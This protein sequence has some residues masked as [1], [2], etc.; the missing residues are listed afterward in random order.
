MTAGIANAVGVRRT[1]TSLIVWSGQGTHSPDN[2]A[3]Q[4]ATQF[5]QAVPGSNASLW[6]AD[7]FFDAGSQGCGDGP[8]EKVASLMRQLQPGQTLEI[9]AT[10]PSVAVDLAA[11]CRMTGHTLAEQTT[12]RYLLRHA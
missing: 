10:D 5:P 4:G 8:L 12:D 11:W 2:D 1:E 7:A 9:H 3:V 6:G